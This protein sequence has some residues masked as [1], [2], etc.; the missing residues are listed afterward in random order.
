MATMLAELQTFSVVFCR[1]TLNVRVFLE[2]PYTIPELKISVQ[3]GN[4]VISKDTLTKVLTMLFF[5]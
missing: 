5:V 3:S 2:N 1:G 4:E